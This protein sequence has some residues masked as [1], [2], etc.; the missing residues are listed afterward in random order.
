MS[1][2]SVE[3]SP[4]IP[5]ECVGL[6]FFVLATKGEMT[7]SSHNGYFVDSTPL[8]CHSCKDSAGGVGQVGLVHDPSGRAALRGVI[9][10]ERELP[11]DGFL[12][13]I[14][15]VIDPTP[16]RSDPT[17]WPF[18][19][20]M[21]LQPFPQDIEGVDPSRDGIAPVLERTRVHGDRW[22]VIFLIS[23]VYLYSSF[24]PC[25]GDPGQW[26]DG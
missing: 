8:K 10:T 14:G 23:P 11:S 6:R 5:L 12:V 24:F 19:T 22:C 26:F 13:L 18:V 20:C 3:A 21:N 7:L 4:S 2:A 25:E 1:L 16:I 9:R 17:V 15:E